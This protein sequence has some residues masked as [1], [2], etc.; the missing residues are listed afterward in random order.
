MDESK[1]NNPISITDSDTKREMIATFKF[2]R[3]NRLIF[4]MAKRMKM[5]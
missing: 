1:V 3:S 5:E 2:C 4:F